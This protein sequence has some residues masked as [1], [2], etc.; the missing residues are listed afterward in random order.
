MRTTILEAGILGSAPDMHHVGAPATVL[1]RREFPGAAPARGPREAASQLA[2]YVARTTLQPSLARAGQLGP[3]SSNPIGVL[4]VRE[5]APVVSAQAPGLLP[6]D[7]AQPESVAQKATA[8]QDALSWPR[9]LAVGPTAPEPA[10]LM[11]GTVPAT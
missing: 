8:E 2:A 1:G 5:S 11:T 3:C 4:E 7:S 9:T 10:Q 6:A